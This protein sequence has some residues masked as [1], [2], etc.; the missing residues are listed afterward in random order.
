M[1]TTSKTGV[2][3]ETAAL[4][5]SI[6]SKGG[7]ATSTAAMQI[8]GTYLLDRFGKAKLK[9]LDDENQD[10]ASFGKTAIKTNRIEVG[11]GSALGET[12]REIAI[13]S[14][15]EPTVVDP[16]GNKTT[17]MVV[18]AFHKTKMY[19]AVK[20]IMIPMAAGHQDVINAERTYQ[21]V[22]DWGIPVLCVLSRVRNPKRVAYQYKKF[23][24][25]EKIGT[26]PY[27]ILKDSDVID[28]SRDM[29][30]TAW[31]I[32]QD[33]ELGAGLDK[34]LEEAFQ[35]GDAAAI[36]NIGIQVE[37]Y[38]ESESYVNNFIKPAHLKIDEILMK[39]GK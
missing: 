18:E 17:T 39:G 28:L 31:E 1:A 35:N 24:L 11:D 38:G 5:L 4:I 8:A 36:D 3:T 30:K 26:L 29:K 27:V 13:E 2:S 19:K 12:I 14:I 7:S 10:S 23:F 32:A 16:G 21:M 34:Q 25:S 20:L 37:I 9:E 15:K 33:K 6:N 22:K